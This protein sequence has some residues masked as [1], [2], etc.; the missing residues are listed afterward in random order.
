MSTQVTYENDQI[1]LLY[2]STISSALNVCF[3]YL[4]VFLSPRF[5]KIGN[6]VQRTMP[7]S[8][9]GNRDIKTYLR[10]FILSPHPVTEFELFRPE[11]I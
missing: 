5:L 9:L 6:I 3:F 11:P 4:D 2:D 8:I 10:K 1:F 7:H